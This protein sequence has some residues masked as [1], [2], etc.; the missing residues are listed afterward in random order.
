MSTEKSLIRDGEGTEGPLGRSWII[1][2][3]VERGDGEEKSRDGIE[4]SLWS[5]EMAWHCMAQQ[6]ILM[7]YGMYQQPTL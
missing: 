1:G 7:R 3:S 5:N 6:H 2:S 4:R